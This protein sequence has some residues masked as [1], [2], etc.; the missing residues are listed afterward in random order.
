MWNDTVQYILLIVHGLTT[1][2][3]CSNGKSFDLQPVG[4]EK[5]DPN[6]VTTR[7]V[8]ASVRTGCGRFQGY[9]FPHNNSKSKLLSLNKKTK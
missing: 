1:T 2:V 7:A 9:L 3:C 5:Y 4:K 8:M 6:A